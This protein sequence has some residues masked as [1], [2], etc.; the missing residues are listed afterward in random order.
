[1]NPPLSHVDH[2][3]VA[4]ASLAQ[5]VAWCEDVL[6]VTPGPGGQHP[7]MGTHNRLL[8]I[9]NVDFPRCYLE[10]I[11]ID[12][13]APDPGR[14]RWFDLDDDALRE[15]VRTQ[16]RLVHFVA[17]TEQAAPALQALGQLGIERG[18]LLAAERAT[19]GG[20][21]QWRISVR[22]DGQRL[23]QGGL[24]TLIEW[25]PMHPAATMP[26]CDITLQALVVHHPQ[27]A[28]L[29]AAHQA[30]GLQRVAVR[31][32]PPDL[33]ATLATPRGMVTLASNGT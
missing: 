11:A 30:I 19:P 6:G 21:L 26:G 16:P 32:G 1:M 8:R 17:R 2:L 24:P 10:I 12:P 3:V 27:A 5:G 9:A 18:P 28:D 14:R 23:F 25:G 31:S 22:D 13:Q 7:L 20:L 15:A 33:I 29:Q 4:A